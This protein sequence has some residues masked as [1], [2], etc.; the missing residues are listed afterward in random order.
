[1]R[2]WSKLWLCRLYSA[3]AGVAVVLRR[4]GWL[5]RIKSWEKQ[6]LRSIPPTDLPIATACSLVGEGGS[7]QT[8]TSR[9]LTSRARWVFLSLRFLSPDTEL[10]N[11]HPH[12][13]PGILIPNLREREVFSKFARTKLF[14]GCMTRLRRFCIVLGN[15]SVTRLL[16]MKA[17]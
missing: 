13:T 3:V 15:T 4:S 2:N 17:Y 16:V 7:P 8:R 12:E 6:E 1:M 11:S 9:G 10:R 5:C 14:C